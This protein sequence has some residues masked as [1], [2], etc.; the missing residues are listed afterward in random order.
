[1]AIP[2]PS[3]C[4]F[5][6][7]DVFH[8]I[9]SKISCIILLQDG[10]FLRLPVNAM[11][12]DMTN[13]RNEIQHVFNQRSGNSSKGACASSSTSVMPSSNLAA[14]ATSNPSQAILVNVV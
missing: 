10:E 14:A 1:M 5:H 8:L 2:R 13:V 12:D 6:N 7:V 4:I 3:L 9:Q 11:L